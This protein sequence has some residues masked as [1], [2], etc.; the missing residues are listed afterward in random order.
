MTV[1]HG[2]ARGITMK[3]IHLLAALAALGLAHGAPAWADVKIGLLTTLT[4]P[5]SLSLIHI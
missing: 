4:G 3:R 2:N 5:G 1:R